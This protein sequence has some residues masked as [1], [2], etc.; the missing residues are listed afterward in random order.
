MP[1]TMRA[2][3]LDTFGGIDQLETKELPVPGV[4][5][6]EVLIRNECAG[7]GEWDPFEMSGGFHE[8]GAEAP[9]RF[10]YVPGSD[11][12]GTVVAVGDRVDRFSPGD[13]VYAITLVNPKGGSYAEYV[14]VSQDRVSHIPQGLSVREAG[15]LPVDGITALRGLDDTLAI[16][17]GE[18]VM[19]F[20]ASGGVGHLAIQL[21]KRMG[22]RVFAVASG[23]DGVELAE[24]LGADGAADGREPDVAAKAR[25]FAPDGIDAALVTA[26]GEATDRALEAMRDGGRIAFPNGVMPE[27]RARDE[28]DVQGYDGEP[29]AE[30][31]EE[32]NR[33][34]SA[35]PFEVVIE[36]SFDLE[37]AADALRAVQGHHLGKLALRL[38]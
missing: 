35:G 24:R 8:E 30:A 29:G 25:A 14:A 3:A 13:R 19:I 23:R 37:H 26:G 16:E 10:P 20:G 38:T 6:D 15:V 32:L 12:A 7:I 9:A 28:V 2:A 5:A 1:E 4:G 33:L 17:P 21:A 36:R 27:P 31:I 22:A 34:I 11:C 18:T